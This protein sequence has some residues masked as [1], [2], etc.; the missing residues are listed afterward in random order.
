LTKEDIDEI[1]ETGKLS[2]WDN[3]LAQDLDEPKTESKEVKH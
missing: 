3:V 1:A 2:R